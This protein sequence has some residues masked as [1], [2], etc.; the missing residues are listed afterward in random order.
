MTLQLGLVDVMLMVAVIGGLLSLMAMVRGLARHFAIDSE[1][2]RKLIHIATGCTALAFP[3]IF[4]GSMPVLVLMAVA[5]GILLLLRMPSLANV[6]IGSVLH[7]VQRRS[8]GEIYLAIAI[9]FIFFRSTDAPILYV[10]PIL[11][12]T[13]ADSAS[14]LVG[15]SYGKQ[16]FLIDG[17]TKSLEG[18]AAF[19]LVTWLIAMIVLLLMTDAARGH[20]ILLSLLIAAFSALVEAQSWKGLDN[21]FVPVSVHLFLE[22]YLTSS[23][24]ELLILTAAFVGSIVAMHGL[25]PA[26]RLTRHSAQA[27][28][29]LIFVILSVTAP[30]NA[31]LPVAAIFAYVFAQR[32]E[33]HGLINADLGM[34]GITA[35]VAMLWLFAGELIDQNV[36]NLFNLTFMSVAITYVT[37]MATGRWHS[38]ALIIAAFLALTSLALTYLNPMDAIW[39]HPIW[40]PL[41]PA[42]VIPSAAALL[43]PGWFRTS[44]SLKAFALALLV[45]VTIY[46]SKGFSL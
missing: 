30:F 6:G 39:L 17:D 9:G 19:F 5:I 32:A 45:P 36:I 35:A 7:Q 23:S 37:L 25:A 46:V 11:V 16:R 8:F 38:L 43:V 13:L 29:V 41:L 33:Q 27:F 10:L 31:L 44:P 42:V 2:Q 14:A 18:T 3:L 1:V 28:T 20:V 22:R 4:T 21:L 26:L 12:I 34:L 24:S 40:L 15:T